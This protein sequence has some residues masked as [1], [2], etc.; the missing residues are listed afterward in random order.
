MFWEN[1]DC[2]SVATVEKGEWGRAWGGFARFD[3]TT[4]CTSHVL[5]QRGGLPT[6]FP[7]VLGDVVY[8]KSIL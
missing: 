6:S 3:V 5:E 4:L 7:T 2:V 8:R 1:E